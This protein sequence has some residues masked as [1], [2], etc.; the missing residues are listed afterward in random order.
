MSRLFDGVDD[1]ITTGLGRLAT[2]PATARSFAAIFRPTRTTGF[3]ALMSLNTSAD[4]KVCDFTI[5]SGLLRIENASQASTG[6][7]IS[8]N[9]WVCAWCTKAAGTTAVNSNKYTYSTAAF[10]TNVASATLANPSGTIAKA[11]LGSIMGAD[12][13]EG[14]ILLIAEWD[15][16]LATPE[17]QNLPFSLAHWY[18]TDPNAMWMLDQDDV[19]QLVA[20]LV[21]GAHQ[22]AIVGT[23]VGSQKGATF[24]Y[25]DGAIWLPASVAAGE[26]HSGTAASTGGGASSATGRKGAARNIQ[27]TGSGTSSATGRKATSRT[28]Q[29]TGGGASA[30]IARKSAHAAAATTGGGQSTTAGRK[31]VP[32]TA[33]T[34]GGGASSCAGRKGV[35]RA[36]TTTGAGS[37]TAAGRKGALRSASTTGGGSSSATGTPSVTPPAHNGTASTTGGGAS[38]AAGRKG[39]ARACSGSG[40]GV[41]SS[42]GRKT[43]RGACSTSGGGTAIAS[44]SMTSR[45][46]SCSTSG[47]GESTAIGRKSARGACVTTGGGTSLGV[48]GKP[49]GD[50]YWP[51]TRPGR[52]RGEAETGDVTQVGTG[53]VGGA[54]GDG[55]VNGPST[56]RVR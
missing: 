39:T 26:A 9:E 19:A 51:A 48:G 46:G 5:S 49:V 22:T 41:S 13:F 4:V 30:A 6:I 32:R 42:V 47:G 10:G 16:V 35:T 43:G 25:T 21:G 28:V 14:E 8:V 27:T 20:D 11:N 33:S 17:L 34:S 1:Q 15:R 18:A 3:N 31:G 53:R 23:A 2:A 44:S 45:R 54:R 12:F 36:L 37:S 50:L 24:N 38:A 7:A 55:T 40:G 52:I 56:G 29:T